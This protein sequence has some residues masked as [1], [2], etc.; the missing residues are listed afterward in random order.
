MAMVRWMSVMSSHVG[1]RG[2]ESVSPEES[3]NIKQRSL[4]KLPFE[5][6]PGGTGRESAVGTLRWRGKGGTDGRQE[7]PASQQL[8]LSH[9]VTSGESLACPHHGPAS[10]GEPLTSSS[11]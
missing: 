10:P 5:L 1:G 2:G 6:G 3:Q 7:T 11:D 9:A 4:E 8:G